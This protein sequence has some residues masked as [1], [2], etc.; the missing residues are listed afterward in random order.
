[1]VSFTLTCRA[2]ARKSATTTNRKHRDLQLATQAIATNYTHPQTIN[3]L[4]TETIMP[5]TRFDHQ[6]HYHNPFHTRNHKSHHH[7]WTLIWILVG[8][9]AFLLLELVL[10]LAWLR[11]HNLRSKARWSR[12]RERGVVVVS[13]A[14]MVYMDGIPTG[15]GISYVN[16]KQA[17]RA[18]KE[19]LEREK[20]GR[21]GRGEEG[22]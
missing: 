12:L 1:M 6:H 22:V 19:V 3:R 11:I 21:F 14:A 13:G 5:P 8:V 2:L 7:D 10:A 16:F 17:V 9:G 20:R 18:E 4:R 15:R